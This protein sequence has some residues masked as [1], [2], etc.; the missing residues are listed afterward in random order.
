MATKGHEAEDKL[1][2]ILRQHFIVVQD[3]VLDH[4]KI[5]G[6][7]V[8]I[9]ANRLFRITE[10]IV[11]Q[12]TT[13][14]N[15]WEKMFI[16][17]SDVLEAGGKRTAFIEIKVEKIDEKVA[18][19]IVSAL[20]NLFFNS[21]APQH[22]LIQIEALGFTVFDLEKIACTYADWL[23]TVEDGDLRG[24]IVFWHWRD[25]ASETEKQTGD[26]DEEVTGSFTLENTRDGYGFLEKL[27]G[28]RSVESGRGKLRF[29][30]SSRDIDKSLRAVLEKTEGEIGFGTINVLFNDAGCR[31]G[32]TRKSAKNVRC[33][34]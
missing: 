14:P 15:D 19:T 13:R 25:D 22:A 29:F 23:E 7:V 12:V 21:Q 27:Y 8:G 9:R 16:F 18:Q 32:Y 5:D 34:P 2:K 11:I 26:E 30:I 31:Q 1:F 24:T 17:L 4:H 33:L 28:R 6:L 3:Q 20:T 10:T